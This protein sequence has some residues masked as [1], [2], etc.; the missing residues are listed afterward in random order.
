MSPLAQLFFILWGLLA[1]ASPILVIAL[2][3]RHNKLQARV[4]A[5]EE[6]SAKQASALRQELAELKRQ[7]AAQKTVVEK[8]ATDKAQI[9]KALGDK[10]AIEKVAADQAQIL[11]AAAEKA[12]MEKAAAERTAAEIAAGERAAAEKALA[13]KAAAAE[14]ASLSESTPEKPRQDLPPVSLPPAVVIPPSGS[15]IPGQP[16]AQRPPEP[17]SGQKQ[18]ERK[19]APERTAPKPEHHAPA[20]PPMAARVGVPAPASPLRVSAAKPTMRE[21]MNKVSAFEEALGTNWLQK[22]GIVLLVLGVASFGIY[23]LAALGSLGKVLV[24]YFSAA[25]LL[26]GGIFLERRER[27][28]LLGRTGIGG[29][30]ALLFFT[31]YAMYHV[32]AMRVL[33]SL[34]LDSTLMLVVAGAMAVHTLRYRSQFVT[35]LAFLLGYTTVALSQD[36]V[37]S[38]SAGVIL[39]IGL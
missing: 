5:A 9:E 14:P 12:A 39:A 17:V 8:A 3:V 18:E 7:V 2:Y 19:P 16:V 34:V 27:Y 15:E 11:K 1:L 37:Y 20:A 31:T 29:G 30:W 24:S 32:E 10:A 36:T 22:L 25:A 21:R 38:L 13:E 23:E 33:H 26:G 6:E 4:K 35:G 28:Q